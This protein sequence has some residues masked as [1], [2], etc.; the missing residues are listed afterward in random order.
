MDN[1]FGD[2]LNLEHNDIV[3]DLY[4][5]IATIELEIKNGDVSDIR[6]DTFKIGFENLFGVP[7]EK[8]DDIETII[9]DRNDFRNVHAIYETIRKSLT[10]I[11]DNYMCVKFNYDD[12]NRSVDL[13]ELYSVYNIMYLDL[14]DWLGKVMAYI[15][16]K[17]PDTYVKFPKYTA[18]EDILKNVEDFNLDS[19]PK[20]LSIMDPGNVDYEFVFGDIGD[21]LD[22]TTPTINNVSIDFDIMVNRILRDLTLGAGV[23]NT[24]LLI[25]KIK[26]Y[27]DFIDKNNIL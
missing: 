6:K 20:I 17:N 7:I 14:F 25:R 19:I 12:I 5:M 3:N 26:F 2:E 13:K 23:Y 21:E 1:N 9:Q 8:I 18:I 16:K 24:E 11:Y 27:M 4:E 22:E 15:I 10:R